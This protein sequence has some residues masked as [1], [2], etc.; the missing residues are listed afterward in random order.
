MKLA[1]LRTDERIGLGVAIALH[2]G[3][4]A[5]LV[6][7]PRGNSPAKLPDRM[8]VSL[9][10]DVSLKSTAPDPVPDSR[11]AIA[12]EI[13]DTPQP[14]PADIAPLIPAP[15][16]IATTPPPA[17][18]K[19]AAQ[20]KAAPPPKQA[21]PAKPRP[22]SKTLPK[23][24]GGSL[25][26]DNFLAGTGANMATTETRTPASDIGPS[27]RA[28]LAQSIARQLKPHWN[29]PQGV[30]AEKLVTVL[31]FDLNPDG[32]LKGRPRVVS[33]AGETPSNAPQKG[34]HAE[35]AIRAVELAAPFDLP[36]EYYEAWKRVA[37]FRFDRKL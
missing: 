1:S 37:A 33:Q 28:S 20:P 13:G 19:P 18:V 25:V 30:D 11:A 23:S 12:P 3:L 24:K 36:P 35:R 31:A 7:Q 9:A 22:A 32:S 6:L 34:L 17:A 4:I 2:I 8:T 15:Q 21:A 27:E 5:F 16:P 10:S 26:G 29:A 14:P